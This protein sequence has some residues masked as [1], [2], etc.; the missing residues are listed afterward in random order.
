MHELRAPFSTG[1]TDPSPQHTAPWTEMEVL[2]CRVAL[3]WTR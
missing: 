2:P 1:P 3:G